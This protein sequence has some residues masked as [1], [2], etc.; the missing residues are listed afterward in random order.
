MFAATKK[1]N[2]EG[3]AHG[4]LPCAIEMKSGIYFLRLRSRAARP[5]RQRLSRPIVAGS[6]TAAS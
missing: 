5:S 1:E 3:I 6:G 2:A 4:V